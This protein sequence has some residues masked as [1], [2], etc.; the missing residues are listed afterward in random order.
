MTTTNSQKLLLAIVA[1]ILVLVI[2]KLSGCG[3]T[4]IEYIDNTST[5]SKQIDSLDKRLKQH[6]ANRAK[7][8]SIIVVLQDSMTVLKYAIKSKDQQIKNLKSQNEKE[9]IDISK[10][11]NSDIQKFLS[12]RYGKR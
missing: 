2:Y 1:F 10:F 9:R 12:D 11:T 5:F 7:T 4:K 8:D 3:R 6:E